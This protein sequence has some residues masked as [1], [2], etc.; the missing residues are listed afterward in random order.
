MYK[1]MK[2]NLKEFGYADGN[3]FFGCSICKNKSIGDKRALNCERCAL[4]LKIGKLEKALS[5]SVTTE[6]HDNIVAEAMERIGELEKELFKNHPK[7][8]STVEVDAL[9]A[10]IDEL[11]LEYC[12]N[13]MTDEQLRIWAENQK[14]SGLTNEATPRLIRVEKRFDDI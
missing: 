8:N 14:P 9:Q 13:A 7:R 11:M 2:M 5:Q 4:L 1:V 10:K 12:P 3:Y 6:Y